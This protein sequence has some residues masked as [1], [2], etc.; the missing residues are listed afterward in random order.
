MSNEYIQ[1]AI[2][3]MGIWNLLKIDTISGEIVYVLIEI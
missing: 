2:I 3:D 1:N